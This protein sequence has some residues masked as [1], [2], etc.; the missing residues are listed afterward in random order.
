MKFTDW[1]VELEAAGYVVTNDLITTKRG[2]VLAGKDPYGGYYVRDSM[3]QTILSKPV[4]QEPVKKQIPAEEL[5]LVRARNKDG[6]FI[7]DDPATPDVNEA[8]TTRARKKVTKK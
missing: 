7:P 6:K 8:W 4:K 1:K 5:E 2:D 3:V